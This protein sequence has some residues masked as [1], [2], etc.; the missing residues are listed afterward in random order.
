MTVVSMG[1]TLRNE[2]NLKVRQP[3]Q[4]IHVACRDA[5]RLGRV[6][7]LGD[8]VAEELNVHEV[9]FGEKDAD[10]ATLSAKADFRRLGPRMG[11]RMRPVAKA[12]ADF[13]TGD[14]ERILAGESVEVTVEG[15]TIELAPDEVQIERTPREGLAVTAEQDLVVALEIN[16]TD[17]LV[18][19]GLGRE[20]V[21]K[22]QNMR[23]TRSL[24]VTQRI[25]VRYAT[26]DPY[27]VRACEEYS[28]YIMGETLAVE[29][30]RVADPGES[31]SDWDINGRS[32]LISFEKA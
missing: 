30:T 17:D 4:S 27:L 29:F 22:I 26:D 19:E 20:V 12:I 9:R 23:K 31:A 11:N 16:L 13:G 2:Y 6:R 8:L 14:C 18:R 10:L 24:E 21:N 7:E 1:R 3:L 5:T 25:R 15:E 28:A 32:I